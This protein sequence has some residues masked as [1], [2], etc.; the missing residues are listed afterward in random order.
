MDLI[1]G[2]FFGIITGIITGEHIYRNARAFP[3]VNIKL[4]AIIRIAFIGIVSLIILAKLGKKAF[5]SFIISF[6]ITR[7]IHILIRGFITDGKGS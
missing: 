6:L 3:K 4:Q 1:F 5:L 7:F 2:I